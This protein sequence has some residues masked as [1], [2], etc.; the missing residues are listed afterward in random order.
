MSLFFHAYVQFDQANLGLGILSPLLSKNPTLKHIDYPGFSVTNGE[1]SS[2]LAESGDQVLVNGIGNEI[3]ETTGAMQVDSSSKVTY[4]DLKSFYFGCDLLTKDL[5][6][7]DGLVPGLPTPCIVTIKGYYQ[8][9]LIGQQQFEYNVGSG[10]RNATLQA[11]ECH[12]DFQGVDRVEFTSD[13]PV[14]KAIVLDEVEY[15][16]HYCTQ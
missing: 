12:T 15:T 7:V 16:P 11:G 13:N 1:G 9:K 5:V 8:S 3:L 10:L 6:N 4:F 2:L 14:L